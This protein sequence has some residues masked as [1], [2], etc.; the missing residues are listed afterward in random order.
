MS[1]NNDLET[2]RIVLH[3]AVQMN[4]S[5]EIILKISQK[6]DEYINVYYKDANVEN[7]QVCVMGTEL[8]T[9]PGQ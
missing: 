2:A 4:M 3:N 1:C 5:N 7:G 9:S 6:L 8:L